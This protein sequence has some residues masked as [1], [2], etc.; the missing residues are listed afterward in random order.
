[1]AQAVIPSTSR[2]ISSE[3]LKGA[4]ANA[5]L[6]DWVV[7]TSEDHYASH[8]GLSGAPLNAFDQSSASDSMTVTIQTGEAYVGGAWLGIDTTTDVTLDASTDN[9]EIAVGPQYQTSD[10]IRIDLVQNFTAEEDAHVIWEFWTDSTGVTDFEN[11]RNIGKPDIAR[12]TENE[13]ISGSWTFTSPTT[14]QDQL[15][16]ERTSSHIELVET[17][18]GQTYNIA[19]SNEHLNIFDP[20]GPGLVRIRGSDGL[21][22]LTSGLAVTSPSSKYEIQ[23]NGNDGSGVINFKT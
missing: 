14:I 8:L 19:A 9:Q 23:K 17:D 2:P 15:V 6:G 7:P 11:R 18:T 3:V 22:E 20:D 13:T 12:R 5:G 21:V 10:G 1:M 16:I 4:I